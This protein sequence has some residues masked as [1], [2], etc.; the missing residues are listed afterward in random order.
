MPDS[1]HSLRLMWY[2][3]D[4]GAICLFAKVPSSERPA[5]RVEVKTGPT[6]GTLRNNSSFSRHTGLCRMASARLPAYS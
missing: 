6:P 1:K 2:Y 4:E 3:A 5:N